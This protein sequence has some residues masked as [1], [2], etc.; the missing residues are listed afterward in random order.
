M[1]FPGKLWDKIARNPQRKISGSF[2]F[3]H[4]AIHENPINIPSHTFLSTVLYQNRLFSSSKKKRKSL[5]EKR[6]AFGIKS[7]FNSA[8]ESFL[9]LNIIQIILL[10]FLLLIFSFFVS[11]KAIKIYISISNLIHFYFSENFQWTAEFLDGKSQ[12][13]K[14]FN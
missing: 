6:A 8:S 5:K 7:R 10:L 12:D 9:V 3:H 1:K 4:T 11:C 14:Y 2:K 13:G